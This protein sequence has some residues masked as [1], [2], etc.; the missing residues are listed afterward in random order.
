[1]VSGWVEMTKE[2]FLKAYSN[3]LADERDEIIVIINGKPYTWNR[4]Y[5]E[6]K[7]DTKLGKMIL[8]KMTEL[9]LL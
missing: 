2:N 4:A 8:D 7:R 6:V 1:M 3:L 5:D 9:G